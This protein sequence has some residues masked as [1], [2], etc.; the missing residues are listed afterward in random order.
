MG[1]L[2]RHLDA[3]FVLPR[4]LPLDEERERLAQRHLLPGSLVEQAV[5]LVADGH[6][7]S[8]PPATAAR[9][10]PVELHGRL[11]TLVYEG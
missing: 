1:D 3:P 6:L 4:H 7:R 2:E 10:L 5:E 8:F 11:T 9:N